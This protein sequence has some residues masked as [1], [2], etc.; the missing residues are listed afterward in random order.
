[1]SKNLISSA[2]KTKLAKPFAFSK[3][4]FNTT[5]TYQPFKATPMPKFTNIFKVKYSKPKLYHF[6]DYTNKLA[7]SKVKIT[8]TRVVN[9]EGELKNVFCRNNAIITPSVESLKKKII[10]NKNDSA[11][12]LSKQ[13]SPVELQDLYDYSKENKRASR[14][15]KVEMWLHSL[16]GSGGDYENV[17]EMIYSNKNL[18]T[19]LDQFE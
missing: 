6:S 15:F 11:I 10:F 12:V 4:N 8:N 7:T 19:W 9:A 5:G 17:S 3:S 16:Y 13:S 1:M 2:L 18:S 14:F